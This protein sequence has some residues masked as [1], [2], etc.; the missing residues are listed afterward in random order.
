MEERIKYLEKLLVERVKELSCL[1]EIS[2]ICQKYDDNLSEKLN[3]LANETKKGWEFPEQLAVFI[4]VNDLIIGNLPKTEKTLQTKL[5]ID[6][7]EKGQILVYYPSGKNDFLKEEQDLLH[8]IG[9]EIAAYIERYLKRERDKKIEEILRGNDRLTI[10]AELTAGIAHELNTPLGSIL[11]YSEILLKSEKENSKRKDLQKIISATKNAR[12]IVKRLMYFSC[13]MP[14]QFSLLNMN[15][16]ISENI[17]FLNRQL[18]EKKVNLTFDLDISIP[19]I[20]LDAVQFSQVLFNLV[21]NA[22]SAVKP[23]GNIAIHTKLI[24]DNIQ[25]VISDNGIGISQENQAHIFKPFFTTKPTGEGTGLGLSVVHGIVKAHN[26]SISLTS[27]EGKGTSFNLLF[28][29]N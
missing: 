10:L 26:G 5:I 9:I 12:E 29:L 4:E 20:R 25:L 8:Q 17:G 6:G 3:K 7:Q 18:T 28:P 23:N 21:L 2:K 19:L 16:L 13:E 14:Q 22:I 24:Q 1:F 11:G 27:E 15:E